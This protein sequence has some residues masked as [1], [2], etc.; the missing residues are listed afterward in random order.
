[1]P[2]YRVPPVSGLTELLPRPNDSPMGGSPMD[3]MVQTTAMRLVE[4]AIGLLR[5]AARL[6]PMLRGK[7]SD[8]LEPF[9]ASVPD[10]GGDEP[11]GEP[12]RPRG[13]QSPSQTY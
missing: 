2:S 9:G 7:I 1:M 10:D 13:M 12:M 5:K 6:D 8:A 3:K 11:S 4:Q